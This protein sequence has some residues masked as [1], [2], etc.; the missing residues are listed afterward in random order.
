MRELEQS[1]SLVFVSVT[2]FAYTAKLKT[3]I[4]IHGFILIFLSNN[5]AGINI[6]KENIPILRGKKKKKK[7]QQ[8]EKKTQLTSILV[9]WAFIWEMDERIKKK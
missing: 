7:R 3:S 6:I 9:Y 4:K 2:D 5:S 1:Y 8:Q